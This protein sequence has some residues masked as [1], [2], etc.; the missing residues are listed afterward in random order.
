[1]CGITNARAGYTTSQ[2]T[3]PDVRHRCA[4]VRED[5][6]AFRREQEEFRAAHRRSWE[7]DVE[8]KRRFA[9]LAAEQAAFVA[10]IKQRRAAEF[11]ALQVRA[12]CATLPVQAT[13]MIGR[14]PSA[15]GSCRSCMHT[16]RAWQL[17]RIARTP[18]RIEAGCGLRR[19]VV[20]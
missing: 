13:R 19:W 1:M 4:Q 7:V 5:E 3:G 6:A 10:A 2:V 15:V 8:E 18:A 16:R 11:A 12:A 17:A 14:L 9:K 20:A